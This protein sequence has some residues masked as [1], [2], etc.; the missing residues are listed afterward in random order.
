MEATLTTF[1]TGLMAAAIV[2]IVK[3][4]LNLKDDLK[5]FKRE[6]ERDFARNYD[7]EKAIVGALQPFAREMAGMASQLSAVQKN[8]NTLLDRWD[9]PPSQRA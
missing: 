7:M 9:I 1:V 2:G 3:M 4:V 6:V 5:D 8:M